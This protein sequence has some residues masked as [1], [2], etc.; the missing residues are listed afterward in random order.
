M[1]AQRT[2][3]RLSGLSGFSGSS[4][5]ASDLADKPDKT[6]EID[7]MNQSPFLTFPPVLIVSRQKTMRAVRESLAKG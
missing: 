1:L 4:G 7:H 6:D 5:A 2:W 3:A